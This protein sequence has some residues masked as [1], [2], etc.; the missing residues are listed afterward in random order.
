MD[1]YQ[2]EDIDQL[3]NPQWQLLS[4]SFYPNKD[5]DKIIEIKKII[6]NNEPDIIMLVEIGGL[7]SL[8]NFNKYFLKNTYKPYMAQSNSDRGIDV[9]YL[10]KNSSQLNVKFKAYTK[11]KLSNGK[12]LARGLFELKVADKSN[13]LKAFFYLTHLKS[14][15]DLK[16][17]DFEG[18]NQRAAEVEYIC[19][20]LKEQQIKFPGIPQYLTGDLNGII[21]KEQTEPE[22]KLFQKMKYYDAFEHL[23]LEAQDRITYYYFDKSHNRSGFQLDY[24]LCSINHASTIHKDS[25]VLGFDTQYCAFPPENL[26]EKLKMPSDHLPVSIKLTL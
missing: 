14:K 11:D 5:L 23:D 24:F 18:R 2:G 7:E 19:Q 3:N 21:Y 17:E 9:G 12:R 20:K 16:K 26:K 4:T 1:K 15:L 8:N 10:V 6:D 13:K 22:L 25:Q